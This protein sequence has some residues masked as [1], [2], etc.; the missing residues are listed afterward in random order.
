MKLSQVL[1]IV[2]VGVAASKPIL[3]GSV[4]SVLQAVTDNLSD[5]SDPKNEGGLRAVAKEVDKLRQDN[6]ALTEA[7]LALHERLERLE[8]K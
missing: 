6:V 5:D 4:G 7:I 2:R 3:P 8:G 1:K